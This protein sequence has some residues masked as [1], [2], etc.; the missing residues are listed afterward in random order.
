LLCSKL[1]L[2]LLF[3]LLLQPLQGVGLLQA[4]A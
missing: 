4:A 2:L 3:D 1:L